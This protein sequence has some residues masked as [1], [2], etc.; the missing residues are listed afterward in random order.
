[1]DTGSIIS[2]STFW[3]GSISRVILFFPEGIVDFLGLVLSKY[4]I[5]LQYNLFARPLD[6]SEVFE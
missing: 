4:Y 3:I 5:L 1:M 6:W 2:H